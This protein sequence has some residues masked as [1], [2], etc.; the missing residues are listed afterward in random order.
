MSNPISNFFKKIESW[1][2]SP[3]VTAAFNTVA[4]VLENGGVQ[5]IVNDIAALTPNK[6]VQEVIT[7][8]TKYGIPVSTAI[9]SGVISPGNALLNLATTLVQKNIK[10]T[11]TDSIVQTAIQLAV[12]AA[13]AA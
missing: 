8:Y 2:T 1:F 9:T 12:T 4:Q 5:T 10:N 13:K 7:A 3:K 6:T 11:A